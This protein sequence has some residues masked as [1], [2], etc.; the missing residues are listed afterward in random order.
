MDGPDLQQDQSEVLNAPDQSEQ[1]G[2]VDQ[3]SSQVGEF[4]DD[5]QLDVFELKL[6]QL[7]RSASDCDLV[8]ACSVSH[9]P[10]LPTLLGRESPAATVH[11]GLV[12]RITLAPP[13]RG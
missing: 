2:L 12:D 3:S 6:N 13:R 10:H 7:A 5:S 11:A 1:D 8:D 9:R 4:A